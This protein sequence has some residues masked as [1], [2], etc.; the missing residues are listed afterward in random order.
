MSYVPKTI[1]VDSGQVVETSGYSLELPPFI[2]IGTVLR[3][4]LQEG[5]ETQK[6]QKG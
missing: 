4:Q 6:R 3:T 1:H 2:P 5:K